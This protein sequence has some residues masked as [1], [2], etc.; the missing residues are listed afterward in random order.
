MNPLKNLLNLKPKDPSDIVYVEKIVLKNRSMF[1]ELSRM[2]IVIAVASG[3]VWGISKADEATSTLKTLLTPPSSSAPE[4]T[5]TGIF[6]T[7]SAI[8]NGILFLDDSQG[9]KYEGVDIFIIDLSTVKKVE[10]NTDTPVIL[11]ISDIS[12]GDRIIARGYIHGKN[13]DN[14]EDII[15]FSATS[16][17]IKIDVATSTATT[18]L[19]LASTTATSTATTTLDITSSSTATTTDSTSSPQADASSTPSLLENITN[20]VEDVINTVTD[21]TQNIVD[22]ITGTTT[23]TST[24]TTFDSQN[25]TGQVATST[26]PVASST[27]V[28]TST[29][30]TATDTQTT[31]A[32]QNSTEQATT[33]AN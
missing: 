3:I 8:D 7:V 23:A 30:T 14:V 6:G 11:S 4:E 25:S 13:L 24:Q 19:D 2:L 15:S 32:T 10:T 31:S 20:V 12:V 28:D 16:S 18:T 29:Q 9:S 5:I 17:K 1:F 27:S 21:T 22:A 26:E 33:T